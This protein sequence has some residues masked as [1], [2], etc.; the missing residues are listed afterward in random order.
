MSA[1]PPRVEIVR[2]QRKLGRVAWRLLYRGQVESE[3]NTRKQALEG[4]RH[5]GID[6]TG[7]VQ[8]RVEEL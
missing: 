2:V 8:R 4:A 1:K 6:S 7:Y 3:Y 5:R